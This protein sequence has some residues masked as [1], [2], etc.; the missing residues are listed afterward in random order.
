MWDISFQFSGLS[1]LIIVSTDTKVSKERAFFILGFKVS[2]ANRNRWKSKLE[3][4][5][6]LLSYL[7]NTYLGM[8]KTG[9]VRNME[10]RSGNP[11]CIGKY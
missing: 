8:S 9:N 6:V 10:E 2:R 4:N 11:Y 3:L 5:H 1:Q 7:R